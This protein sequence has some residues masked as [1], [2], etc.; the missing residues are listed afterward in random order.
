MA[1]SYPY[2]PEVYQRQVKKWSLLNGK[3]VKVPLD[4]PMLIYH[5]SN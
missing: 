3:L 2:A 4:M 1:A 5:K